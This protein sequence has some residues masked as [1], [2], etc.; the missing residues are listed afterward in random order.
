MQTPIHQPVLL[1]AVTRLLDP[2]R[3]Q[4]YLDLT[5]GYGGHAAA[6]KARIHA[7]D[8]LV[9]VD[10]D[11]EAVTALKKGFKQAELLQQDFE[12]AAAQLARSGRTFDMIMMDLGVSSVQL[13]SP[14]R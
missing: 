13:S 5:A 11:A 2:R 4:S 7:E 12:S 14:D 6:I 10:R 1:D 3:G 9:L 8:K